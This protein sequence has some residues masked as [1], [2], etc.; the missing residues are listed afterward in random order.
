MGLCVAVSGMPG[1]GSS[2]TA[3]LLAKRLNLEHFSA[4]DYV[5]KLGSKALKTE[6]PETERALKMWQTDLQTEKFNKDLDDTVVKKGKEG[7]IVIDGKLAIYFL[8][9]IAGM[10]VWLKCPM[11]TRAERIA[12][13]D[14]IAFEK[15][16]ST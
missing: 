11:D 9:D 2:T 6:V 4:G 3:K 5:K 8:K 13:R 1:A 14:G 15:A 10:K 16:C 12:L 7:N